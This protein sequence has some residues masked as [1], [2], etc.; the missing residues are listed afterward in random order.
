MKKDPGQRI[1]IAQGPFFL[2][3]RGALWVRTRTALAEVQEVPSQE[4][5]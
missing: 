4:H 3:L 2:H 5:R 1:S